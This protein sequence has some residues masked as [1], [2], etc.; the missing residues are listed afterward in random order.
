MISWGYYIQVSWQ[1][2]WGNQNTI[3][4]KL[5]FLAAIFIGAIMSSE[6]VVQFGD[7]LLLITSIPN[8]L[9]A[10]LLSPQVAVE[11]EDYFTRLK[12]GQFRTLHEAN[13]S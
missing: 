10:Y 12:A 3:I 6:V 13:Q 11:L 2:L 9:G 7:A 5:T 1:Y 8:L 4:Y